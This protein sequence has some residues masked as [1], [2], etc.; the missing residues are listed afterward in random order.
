MCERC[1]KK[2][3]FGHNVSFSK[4]RTNRDWL[5]NVQSKVLVIDGRTQRISICTRCLR[6]LTKPARLAARAATTS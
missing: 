6:T 5:P 2:R 4:R 1:G 3:T